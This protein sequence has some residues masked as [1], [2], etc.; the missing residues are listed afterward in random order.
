M[1]A[2]RAWIIEWFGDNGLLYLGALIGLVTSMG[3]SWVRHRRELL[4]AVRA[5]EEARTIVLEGIR[6][7]APAQLVL[8][9][10]ETASFTV[11]KIA[12]TN[13]KNIKQLELDL[14]KNSSLQGRWSCIAGING[15]GKSAILQA[16]CIVLLGEKLVAELGSSLLQRMIRRTP[17][18]TLPGAKI[19]AWIRRNNESAR[20]IMIPL[21]KDGIDERM[22]RDD[23]DYLKM[24]E[25]WEELKSTVVV[26]YGAA[27]N[28]TQKE[29]KDNVR[30]AKQVQ[31]QM[32]LF[33]PMTRLA[34]VAVL[35]KPD[36][37][38]VKKRR[39][40]QRLIERILDQEELGIYS[41]G[42]RLSFGRSGTRVDAIDLPDGF[43]ST[44]AW[45]ADL[46]TA[47]HDTAPKGFPRETD[48]SR[49]TGIVLLDEIDLHLHPS[50]A[51]SIV[52]KLR[53]VLPRVQFIVTTHSPLVLGS[54]DR[55]ELIILEAD[56][57][58]LVTTRTLDRQVFGFSMDEIYKWLMRTP[59]HSSV[60]EEKVANG[61]DPNLASYLYQSPGASSDSKGV[62]AAD[63]QLLVKD[64][65]RLL[66]DVKA[67]DTEGK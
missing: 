11:E 13:F 34:D 4:S 53:K 21:N 23:P 63:S 47:W 62:S 20:R 49:I 51:R 42:D 54:F 3:I 32:T 30:E 45:L 40:V 55:N 9:S 37:D 10:P 58:G 7:S 5:A 22:L 41:E 6:E 24:R 39:T 33:D 66:E 15:A 64:L 67:K 46:C 57:E 2:L 26:S 60:L 65:E 61:D 29:D 16:L 36:K 50:M 38:S 44:V 48:P 14:M 31:R 17:N 59:P 19:E 27:R 43:R 8:R 12:I 1:T 35:L 18:G 52:P 56:E 28:L 25:T